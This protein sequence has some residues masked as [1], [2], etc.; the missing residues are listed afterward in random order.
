MR[1]FGS[2]VKN[3]SN[4]MTPYHNRE[5][6]FEPKTLK[7][8]HFLDEA[9]QNASTEKEHLRIITNYFDETLDKKDE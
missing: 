4:F 3:D 9:N 8:E 7:R 1:E 6:S 2:G 5:Y